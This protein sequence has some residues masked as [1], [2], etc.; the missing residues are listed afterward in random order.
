[1]EIQCFKHGQR[2]GGEGGLLIHYTLLCVVTVM[3]GVR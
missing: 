1:M 2:E 3:V